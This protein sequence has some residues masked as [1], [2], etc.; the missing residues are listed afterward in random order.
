MKGYHDIGGDAYGAVPRVEPPW[1]YWEKKMEAI[2]YLL[3]DGIRQ[4]VSLDELRLGY[5]SFGIEKYKAYSFY[6]RRLE[7]LLN[8]L[9]EK[10]VVTRDEF[11]A[12]LSLVRAE[13]ETL[14]GQ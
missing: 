11:E 4:M 13:R 6:R 8:I 10:G 1:Q 12:E 2:R 9:I 5:E 3:G 14:N 7:A